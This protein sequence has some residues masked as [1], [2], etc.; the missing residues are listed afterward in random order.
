MAVQDAAVGTPGPA[1][2]FRHE[3]LLYANDDEYLAGTVPFIEGALD[4]H[5]P[6]LVAVPATQLGLLRGHIGRHDSAL[7]QFADME[8][9]GR[10]PAWI[11]PA[12]AAFVNTHMSAGRTA[13]GI[14]EPIWHGRSSDELVEC[15]RHEAL[16]NMAFADADGFTLLCPYN[17]TLL[18]PAVISDAHCTHPY[19]T[20]SSGAAPS[21]CFDE[22][23]PAWLE[24]PLSAV[25]DDADVLTFNL[26]R[27][28]MVR[29]RVAQAA[30]DAGMPGSRID[31]LVLAVSEVTTNSVRYAGGSGQI[32]FWAGE[33]E[34]LCDIQDRGCITDHLVGR[35]RPGLD[36]TRG[37]GLWVVHQ[38]CDLV[39][40]R[41]GL[42]HG[43]TIR[44][45]MTT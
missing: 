28:G 31:D 22:D 41:G 3:A 34:F 39:Q 1:R 17:T 35:R 10:N 20:G 9:I 38:L 36:Q 33:S 12:W 4:A 42:P 16:L 21:A 45:H 5:E 6:I 30:A 32:A 15:V 7:V 29:H 11:I 43:Q 14:G 13:R 2:Q 25:P 24:S 18:D 40:I 37:H 44:L 26:G 19:V 27:L 8:Q 23:I